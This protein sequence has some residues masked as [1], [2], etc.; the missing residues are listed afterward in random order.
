MNISSAAAHYAAPACTAYAASKFALEGLSEALA[1]E[2]GVFGI[3]VI[4]V[5]PGAF[6]TNL[7][8]NLITPESHIRAYDGTPA[9]ELVKLQIDTN[10]KQTGDPVK[11][12][13]KVLEASIEVAGG[14]RGNS[15]DGE[16]IRLVLGTD[17]VGAMQHK[18]GV[19]QDTLQK[20]RDIA[21]STDIH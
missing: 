15:A 14:V 20:M 16:L 11:A 2:V 5:T 10:G 9:R 13:Q 8:S 3:K 4:A 18:I 1:S 12:A 7:V 19:L 21:K 6:R 17:A